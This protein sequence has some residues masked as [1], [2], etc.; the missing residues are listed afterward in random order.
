[1]IEGRVVFQSKFSLRSAVSRLRRENRKVNR[2]IMAQVLKKFKRTT[3]DWVRFEPGWQTKEGVDKQGAFF[4]VWTENKIMHFLDEGTD[5]RWAIM[6]SDWQS[7]TRPR[8]VSS[9]PGAG[10][11]VVRGRGLMSKLKMEPRPG[12]EAR[13]FAKTIAAQTQKLWERTADEATKKVIKV[14]IEAT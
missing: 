6:S 13:D 2:R 7:K 12:I 5:V 14:S 3:K 10:Q 11:V 1:M 8:I 4:R 9:R